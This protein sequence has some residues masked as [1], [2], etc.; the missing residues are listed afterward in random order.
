MDA[1]LQRLV[2]LQRIVKHKPALAPAPVSKSGNSDGEIITPAKSSLAELQKRRTTE[3][4]LSCLQGESTGDSSTPPAG[5]GED[6]DD[7][8]IDFKKLQMQG[9][10]PQSTIMKAVAAPSIAIMKTKSMPAAELAK[11]AQDVVAEPKAG[12]DHGASANEGAKEGPLKASTSSGTSRPLKASNSAG[13]L[14]ARDFYKVL[15]Q[16]RAAKLAKLPQAASS[17]REIALVTTEDKGKDEA[18]TSL[19]SPSSSR[20]ITWGSA[21][22]LPPDADA[23]TANRRLARTGTATSSTSTGSATSG[24]PE[25]KKME[26]VPSKQKLIHL[27]NSSGEFDLFPKFNSSPLG[28]VFDSSDDDDTSSEEEEQPSWV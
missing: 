2:S 11:L 1:V 16:R 28:L 23:S 25:A 15:N 5:K 19:T 20:K 13:S 10:A 4:N 7:E 12:S 6:T 9:A 3:P 21:H 17:C 27:G 24:E 26:K 18:S 22:V 8:V 14:P